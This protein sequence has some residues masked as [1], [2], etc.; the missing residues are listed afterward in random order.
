MQKEESRSK[1]VSGR[2]QP[3]LYKQ[4]DKFCEKKKWSESVAIEEA[5]IQMIRK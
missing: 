1:R 3:S 2:L 4:F 5:I